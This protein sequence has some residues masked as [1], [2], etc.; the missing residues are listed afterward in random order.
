MSDKPLYPIPS[1]IGEI[2]PFAGDFE[3]AHVAT[4]YPYG[5]LRCEMRFWIEYKPGKGFREC[6][7]SKNPKNG[8]WNKTHVETYHEG[9]INYVEAETGHIKFARFSFYDKKFASEFY[10]AFESGLSF[11]G[12]KMLKFWQFEHEAEQ[13]IVGQINNDARREVLKMTL[14]SLKKWEVEYKENN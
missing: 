11:E 2:L 6:M 10:A 14:E 5:R 9:L 12:K 4:N 8:T 7:R 3:S 13:K 1:N